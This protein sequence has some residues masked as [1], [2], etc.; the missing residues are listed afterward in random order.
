MDHRPN[1]TRNAL[2]ST[3][4]RVVIHPSPACMAAYASDGMATKRLR[5][6][7]WEYVIKRAALLPRPIYLTF[8]DEDEGDAYVRR[9]EQLLDRGVVPDEF[10]KPTHERHPR[11]RTAMIDYKETQ[12]VSAADLGYLG[13]LLDRLPPKLELREVTFEWVTRWISSLKR[14]DNLA[15]STIRHHAGALAR[16]LDWVLA[17]GGIPI[18]PLRQLPRGYANYTAEDAAIVGRRDGGGAA[19]VSVDRDRR[20]QGDEEARIRAILCGAKPA[21]KQRPLELNHAEALRALFDLALESA[22]RMSE[23]YTLTPAQVDFGKRTIFLDRTKNGSKR[24]VPITTVAERVLRDYMAGVDGERLFP[25]WSGD[26][27]AD[28]MKRCTSLLSRQFGRVFAAAGC[29]DLR[30]H[31]LRHEATSRLFE[32]TTLTDLQIAKITGHKDIR[33]LARYANLRG[34]DLADR[35]W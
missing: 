4:S 5:N 16:C 20:L 7:K 25:W 27:A 21:G 3:R 15:P 12:P 34:S 17:S 14:D 29:V 10:R 1:P 22:M 2:L 32:R 23:M 24:Q 35:L 28:E 31:D 11:L 8:D 18:N 30:F 19:K 26:R 6:G 13:V 9:T 33:M